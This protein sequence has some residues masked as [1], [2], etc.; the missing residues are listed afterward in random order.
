M[1]YYRICYNEKHGKVTSAV[2]KGSSGFE[3]YCNLG[4]PPMGYKYVTATE[5]T[6]E[7][8]REERI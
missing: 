8:Y 2:S 4:H 7:T 5:I 3:A 6:L 1:K